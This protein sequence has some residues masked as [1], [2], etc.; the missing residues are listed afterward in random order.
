LKTPPPKTIAAIV[1][2]LA[3]A[4]IV[5]T[6]LAFQHASFV[7]PV[8]RIH[9]LG[10]AASPTLIYARH[11]PV[12]PHARNVGPFQGLGTWV[13]VYDHS[14]WDHPIATVDAMA[15][16]GVQTLYLQTS[17]YSRPY[18]I[19]RPSAVSSFINEA[20]AKGMVVV[21]WYLPGLANLSLDLK[22][23]LAAIEFKTPGG[24]KFD[25]FGLDIE[26]QIVDP[27]GKR[28]EA[29]LSLSQQIRAGAPTA[30]PLGAITPSPVALSIP[31][32]GWPDFPFFELNGIYDAFVPMDYFT[33]KAHGRSEVRD[34][35]ALSAQILRST[36][37]DAAVPIAPIGGIAQGVSGGEAKGFVE[38]IL[39]QN[40]IGGSLYDFRTTTDPKVWNQLSR[41]E[42]KI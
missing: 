10:D 13:D 40:L 6:I 4:V 11:S 16:K 35:I 41:I 7:N 34:Y 1:A 33:S 9:K 19:Y 22:R 21:S 18:D 26:A 8:T 25:G 24:Q 20:H 38:A 15:S 39:D 31:P 29:L 17:N 42:T 23:S 3:T 5:G 12:P 2:V 30:Y 27:P 28:T 32:N 36:T 37:G 14:S